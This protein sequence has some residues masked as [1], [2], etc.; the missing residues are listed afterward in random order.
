M[1]AFP[2]FVLL[3]CPCSCIAYSCD[4]ES[5]VGGANERY[6]ASMSFMFTQIG[7][8]V[9]HRVVSALLQLRLLHVVHPEAGLSGFYQELIRV[10]TLSQVTASQYEDTNEFASALAQ[11]TG[12]RHPS[13]AAVPQLLSVHERPSRNDTNSK[14][15]SDNVGASEA[16]SAAPIHSAV[17][18]VDIMPILSQV[19]TRW[20]SGLPSL[21]TSNPS[22]SP[23]SSPLSTPTSS[24]FPSSSSSPAAQ[25]LLFSSLRDAPLSILVVEDNII[26]QKVIV[27]MLLKI[28]VD[29]ANIGIAVNGVEAVEMAAATTRCRPWDI[30]LM[31]VQMPV[32][33]GVEATKQIVRSYLD[34]GTTRSTAVATSSPLHQPIN[35]ARYLSVG[36]VDWLP[37][38]YSLLTVKSILF[39]WKNGC[40]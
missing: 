40:T 3:C 5:N 7:T 27:S 12:I 21:S 34:H 9:Q 24:P 39:K 19:V 33:D 15:E 22:L 25:S 35:I 16:G 32:L 30:I 18:A 10:C 8:S 4:H 20:T 38:P 26:N 2:V 36:M 31:D 13:N 23:F 11:L 6:L 29:R 14:T 37:K 1:H 28:G 17:I